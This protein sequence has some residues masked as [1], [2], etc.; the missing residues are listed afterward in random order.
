[1]TGRSKPCDFETG[2]LG[3]EMPH[4][5]AGADRKPPRALRVPTGHKDVCCAKGP[6]PG[7]TLCRAQRCGTGST[8]RPAGIHSSGIESTFRDLRQRCSRR[9]LPCWGQW[10]RKACRIWPGWRH[11][12]R[13]QRHGTKCRHIRRSARLYD[14]SSKMGIRSLSQ[15]KRLPVCPALRKVR[16]GPTGLI[17]G[18]LSLR[19]RLFTN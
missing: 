15:L 2:S 5:A 10:L 7:K 19:S 16:F 12:M 8:C 6:D 9:E 14:V 13:M 17:A 1:M 3:K 11:Q 4:K 18:A